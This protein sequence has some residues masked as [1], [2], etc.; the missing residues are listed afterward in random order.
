MKMNDA[1][2]ATIKVIG[3]RVNEPAARI[4]MA[5]LPTKSAPH[6]T[7][8]IACAWSPSSIALARM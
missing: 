8:I 6:A 4:I 3:P 1:A 7:R 5:T 2:S